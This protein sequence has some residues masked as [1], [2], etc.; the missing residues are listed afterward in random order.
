[1]RP[2]QWIKLRTF[3]HGQFSD[4]HRLLKQKR[5]D[6]HTI[7]LCL[8]ALNESFTI[9]RIIRRLKEALHDRIP[10]IDEIMVIDSGSTDGTQEICRKSGVRVYQDDEILPEMGNLRG[11]GENLWK[12]LYIAKGDIILWLDTDIRN[13]EE[14][15]VTG[16]IGPLLYNRDISFV[17]G[18][19]RRPIQIGNK[20]SATGGGRVT[21][22]LVK[23]FFNVLFP[24]LALFHQPLSGEY[25]GRRD[26]LERLPF[27]TGY[28]VETGLLIDIE[29]RFGLSCMAQVDLKVRIHRNQDLNSL[30]K[31]SF[32]ILQVLLTR[33]EQ[34]G[35]LVLMDS[36]RTQ[37]LSILKN[38]FNEYELN[39][40]DIHDIERPPMILSESYQ[41][42]R[43]L[44]EEDLILLDEVQKKRSYPFVSV[45]PLLDTKLI[46]LNGKASGKKEALGQISALLTDQKIVSDYTRLLYEFSKRESTMSTAIG[47]GIAIPHVLSSIIQRLKIVVFRQKTGIA[48]NSLDGQPV[49]LIFAVVCPITRRQHYLQILANLAMILKDEKIRHRLL[50]AKTSEDFIGIFRKSEV[51]KRFERELRTVE[52]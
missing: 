30:R 34:Q 1:M 40:T 28:G 32:G 11:K 25:A 20:I 4:I 36:L 43:Q 17:K 45:S 6:K 21:E 31:M 38:E 39:L 24:Q 41:K 14:H 15:F 13:M 22:I 29:N 37:F 50:T 10:L 47:G 19:Y 49:N 33:A 52:S 48:F 9:G 51:L 16:L 7:S 5:Q 3:S 26:L 46:E 2:N 8:P 27:F 42:K 44:A 18:F 12:S 35:K 23:P